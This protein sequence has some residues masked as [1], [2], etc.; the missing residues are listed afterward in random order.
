M[1]RNTIE[2]KSESSSRLKKIIK[3][4]WKKVAFMIGLLVMLLWPITMGIPTGAL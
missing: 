1:S 3:E 4:Y 2:R